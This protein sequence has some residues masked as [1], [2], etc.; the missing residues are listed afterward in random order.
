MYTD[1]P[2]FSTHPI[3]PNLPLCNSSLYATVFFFSQFSFSY[4][5]MFSSHFVYTLYR[6][7]LSPAVMHTLHL[8]ASIFFFPHLSL[9]K[10]LYWTLLVTREVPHNPPLLL[11]YF[12]CLSSFFLSFNPRIDL[13][14]VYLFPS[15]LFLAG[16]DNF[17]LRLLP[18]L[19][20]AFTFS[21]NSRLPPITS[22]PPLI[23]GNRDHHH[24][25]KCTLG[26]TTAP[27]SCVSQ[28]SLSIPLTDPIFQQLTRTPGCCVRPDGFL[29]RGSSTQKRIQKWKQ[30]R[31]RKS[32]RISGKGIWV[33]QSSGSLLLPPTGKMEVRRF[34]MATR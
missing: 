20:T 17:P 28:K 23:T 1:S 18:S 27:G 25:A 6:T 11:S 13:E 34:S 15:F 32:V 29:A 21:V 26:R 9:T 4:H 24:H 5:K 8:H 33:R 2:A 3:L 12:P 30:L 14:I 19:L 22:F 10:H 7:H 31:K 16:K